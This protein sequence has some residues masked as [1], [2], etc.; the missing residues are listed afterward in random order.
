MEIGILE[1]IEGAREAKGIVVIIDVFR[2]F[3]TE[4]YAFDSGA[5]RIIA[6]ATPEEEAFALK[7]NIPIP[8][9]QV[10]DMRKRSKDLIL[11][12]VLQR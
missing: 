9:L 10:K 5:V 3:S 8:C 2:A 6:T 12:T 1:F 4:C 7:R 11:G